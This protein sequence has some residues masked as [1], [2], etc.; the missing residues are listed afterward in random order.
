LV[1]VH[2]ENGL[3]LSSAGITRAMAAQLANLCQDE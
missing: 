2:A 1:A 3:A